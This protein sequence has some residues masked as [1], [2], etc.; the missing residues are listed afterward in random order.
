LEEEEG[1][2]EITS[3]PLCWPNNVARTPP[4]ARGNPQFN[5]RTIATAVG[6]CLE[7]INR[8]NGRRWDY[9]D[10]NVIVS[11]NLRPKLSGLPA[12][13]QSEPADTGIAVYFQLRFYR[14]GKPYDRPLVMTCD[15]WRKSADNIYAIGKHIESQRAQFRWGCG[16]VEQAFAGYVA[17]PEKC[18]GESWWTI[19][20]VPS[21]ADRATIEAAY[22]L[23]AKTE[24]P[25][26]GGSQ[27]RWV[28]LQT[29][30]E[31]ANSR[32]EQ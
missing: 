30:F 8:L 14:G 19:L 11:C 32:T 22:K 17:I 18:G 9:S 5:E 23:K 27:E 6:F 12:G 4:H 29:A 21:T 31:Q 13:T 28:K 1:M 2:S 24:H 26:A 3:F 15:K 25:D 16:S 20:G 7:E 10:D